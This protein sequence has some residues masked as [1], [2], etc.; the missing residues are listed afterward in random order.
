MSARAQAQQPVP[1]TAMLLALLLLWPFVVRAQENAL[2]SAIKATYLYKLG[3][4]V[5]WPAGAAADAAPFQICVVGDD[6]F[7]DTLDR[8]VRGQAL[9]ARP[10]LV[11]RFANAARSLPCHVMYLAGSA[12]QSAAEALA[13]LGN[14]PILTITDTA[15]RS[16]AKGIIH[17]VIQDNRVRF[18]IDDRAAAERGLRISSRLLSLATAVRPRG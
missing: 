8:A 17:F 3:P 13:L 15:R 2:E 1:V 14:A 4:F 6:P 16:N 7:G 18:E 10:I 5:D 11:Q 9:G 12:T